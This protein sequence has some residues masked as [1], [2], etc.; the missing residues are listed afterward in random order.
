MLITNPLHSLQ[1]TALQLPAFLSIPNTSLHHIPLLIYHSAFPPQT[2]T[3]DDVTLHLESVGVVEPAWVYSFPDDGAGRFHSGTHEVLVIISGRG[4]M[5]FGGPEYAPDELKEG[6]KNL[7]RTE[8]VVAQGDVVVVPAGVAH[9]L[10]ENLDGDFEVVGAYP[11]GLGN[12]DSLTLDYEKVGEEGGEEQKSK[13]D[14]GK[15]KLRTREEV[16]ET[17]RAVEWF[18]RDPIYGDVGPVVDVKKKMEDQM[19]LGEDE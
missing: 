6:E 5:S 19:V 2:C 12:W 17:V 18:E 7:A 3:V 16:E 8:L 1:I 10:E 14:G 15:R 13:P 4:R 11:L 9:G